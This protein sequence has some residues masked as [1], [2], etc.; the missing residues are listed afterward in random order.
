MDGY[1]CLNRREAKME[2]ERQPNIF[3][4]LLSQSDSNASLSL[5]R[6]EAEKGV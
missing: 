4:L 3:S 2:S 5:N 1:A 6:R